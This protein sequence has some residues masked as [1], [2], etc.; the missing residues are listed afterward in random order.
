MA[1]RRPAG[2]TLV[3][4]LAI[5]SGILSI[6]GAIVLLGLGLGPHGVVAGTITLIIGIVTL[7]VGMF[8]LRG[9]RL[10]RFLASVSF[11]LSI[12]GAIYTALTAPSDFLSSAVGGLLA[13]I[14]LILLWTGRA[15][16][17]F[18]RD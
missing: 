17:W 3:A 5:I 15:S 8:L 9:S 6:I 7:L 13:L 18:A 11:I 10:A 1:A 2:V 16:D 4:I 12:A 14:G